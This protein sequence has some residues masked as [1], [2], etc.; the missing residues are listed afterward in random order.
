M[1]DDTTT[2]TPDAPADA[3]TITLPDGST[4]TMLPMTWQA[5]KAAAAV[6][7]EGGLDRSTAELMQAVEDAVLTAEFKNGRPLSKQPFA[8]FRDVFRAWN[9]AEE[10]AA[11]PPANGQ[12]S[13]TPS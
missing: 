12:I 7:T 9:R 13:E 3:R 2:A 5:M 4:M 6:D 8:V 10:D 11:L 1:S